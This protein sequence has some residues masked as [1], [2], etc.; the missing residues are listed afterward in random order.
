VIYDDVSLWSPQKKPLVCDLS[1]EAGQGKRV[2]IVGPHDA[3]HA[4]LLATAGLWTDGEGRIGR[5]EE[6]QMMFVQEQPRAGSGR[7]REILAAGLDRDVTDDQLQTV[8]KEVGLDAAIA[9]EGGLDAERD[10]AST[11]SA[12]E[13]HALTFARL[14]LAS[15]RFAFLDN[16]AKNVDAAQADR[17]YAA[18]GRSGITYLTADCSD[19]LLHYHNLQ[20]QLGGDGSWHV[21]PAA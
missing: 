11:L 13:L 19:A 8:L 15:P 18:L 17:L 7:L 5:P 20:L 3:C 14:L 9:R 2:A 21:A 10:W 16:P 4:I 1:L 6:G 12:D